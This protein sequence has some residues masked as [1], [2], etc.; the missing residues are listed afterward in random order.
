[1][2]LTPDTPLKCG[3][4]AFALFWTGAMLWWTGTSGPIEICIL[5]LCG[6]LGGL[7][8]YLAMDFIFRRVGLLPSNH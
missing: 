4:V 5:A 1:M 7:G 6:A 3:A 8:W 2:K